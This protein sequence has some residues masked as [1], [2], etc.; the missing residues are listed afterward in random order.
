MYPNGNFPDPVRVLHVIP[1]VAPRYGGPSRAVFSL[2]A[3]AR[4][5]G[6]ESMIATTNADGRGHLA[7]VL[8][9]PVTYGGAPTI[10]FTR[11]WNEGFKYSR[12]LARWLSANVRDFDLVHIHAVFSHSSLAAFR[13]C[14]SRGVLYIVRPLGSLTPWALSRKRLRK[15]ILWHAGVGEM[16]RRAG[17]LHYTTQQERRLT[18]AALQLAKEG[19]VIPVP[20]HSPA[21]ELAGAGSS[22]LAER[23]PALH[24]PPYVL[25]LGRLHPVK[26]LDLLIEAFLEVTRSCEFRDWRL[27]LAGEGDERYVR[28][29]RARVSREAA[30]ERVVFAGWVDGAEK[31]AA[32]RKAALVASVSCQ[33]SL[34][35]SLLES[36][37]HGIPVL[38]GEDVSLA[39]DIREAGAGWVISTDGYGLR[40]GLRCALSDP[41]ERSRRGRAGGAFWA[42]RF[43][44]ARIGEQL[45]N[46]YDA[47]LGRISAPGSGAASSAT[48]GSLCGQL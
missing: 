24:K 17:A 19:V 48:S 30:E 16:L 2:C 18:E 22:P 32:I 38:V 45:R 10:F 47:V 40:D 31:A 3:A 37:A 46:L 43:S 23:I 8:E 25:A 34:G 20:V 44:E 7:I 12:S 6:V 9:T 11:Q 29:L 21:D 33:E 35:L 39:D 26:R 15:R 42:E 4:S 28:S 36:L 5:R 1:A 14:R 27:V 41:A 13:A